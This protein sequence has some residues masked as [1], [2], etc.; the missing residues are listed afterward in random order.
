MSNSSKIKNILMIGGTDCIGGAATVGWQLGN[1]LNKQGYNVKYIV[2]DKY[3]NSS[4]VYE[5]KKNRIT[6]WL[7]N[8][9]KYNISAL[10]RQIAFYIFANDIDFGAKEE[11]LKHPWY[12]NADVIHLHNLHGN[13]FRLNTLVSIAKEKPTVW[14]LHDMWSITANCFYCYD[15]K[16]WNT[17]MHHTNT[18]GRPGNTLWDNSKYLWRK[19]KEIY[20]ESR[21]N[22][23][24]PAV[25]LKNKIKNSILVK[26]K[27]TVIP[28]GI[29]NKI[30][31]N[32]D[33]TQCRKKLN[34][35]LQ[36]KIVLF[37]AQ[38]AEKNPRKGYSYFSKLARN[39]SNNNQVDFLCIG[40]SIKRR[41]GNILFIPFL[42]DF[43][44]LVDYYNSADVLIFP[45]LDEVFGLVTLEAMSCGIPVVCFDL[46]AIREQIMHKVNGYVAKYGDLEDL[47][48]GM[49][50]ILKL[51]HAKINKI[52][53]TNRDKVTKKYSIN[54]MVD[55]YSMLYEKI[56]F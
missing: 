56:Y 10:V 47:Q 46:P 21:L 31:K 9:T 43:N 51:N 36:K 23:V 55:Q 33:R 27:I 5:L 30:F 54:K 52:K 50:Y 53:L 35:S 11:I 38:G 32:K 16:H 4:K 15:C 2:A 25:W 20:N 42:R 48:Q 26:Q 6:H 29:D 18:I 24:T 8:H 14:T 3:S 40:S 45:S 1:H 49:E 41:V 28:N 34:L 12:K 19:K 7:D 17:G 39:C 13:Y 44:E 37:V 22:I